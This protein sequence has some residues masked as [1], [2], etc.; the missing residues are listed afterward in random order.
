MYFPKNKIKTGLYTAGSE[1][2]IKSTGKN[3][4]GPYWRTSAGIYFTGTSPNNTPFYELI[5]QSTTTNVRQGAPAET[6]FPTESDYELGEFIRYFT[7]RRNQSLYQEITKTTYQSI[8]KGEI[9][10]TV[11]YRLFS[12]P[13]KLTG[14]VNEA[15]T[16]NRNVVSLMESREKL[17]GLNDI[18]LDK[19]QYFRY[20]PQD[21]LYTDGT[22]FMTENR[23]IYTGPYHINAKFGPM[24]GAYHT[25]EP[26]GKLL[27]F[28]MEESNHTIIG[29]G[30]DDR[31][32]TSKQT[33]IMVESPKSNMPS[34]VYYNRISNNN[35]I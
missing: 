24:I 12:L 5:G 33:M 1:Y 27:P 31:R 19:I 9:D 8:L 14:K 4:I 10:I 17:D 35:N 7:K 21:N 34:S 6:I 29:V 16:V 23:A 25:E 28:I 11:N 13:W 32:H 15:F 20:K 26:H 18:L 2:V 3:Y 22:E 30:L